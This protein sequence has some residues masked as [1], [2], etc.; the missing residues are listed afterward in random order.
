MTMRR[1]GWLIALVAIC[2]LAACKSDD[3]GDGGG[4]AAGVAGATGGMGGTGTDTGGAGGMGGGA[5]GM[6]GGGAGGMG[7]AGGAGGGVPSA[8][9]SNVGEDVI[10]CPDAVGPFMGTCAPKGTC[11]HRSSNQAKIDALGADAPMELEYRVTQSA[12][13]NHPK[14]LTLP[15]LLMGAS[16]RARTCAGEQ[17]LLWRFVQP[18]MGGMPVAGPGKSNVSIGRYNCNGTFSYYGPSAAP[19]RAAEGFTDPARWNVVE[20]MTDVDPAM[21]GVEQTHIT[22]ATAPN[23]RLTTSPFF[24]PGT[25]TID[26]EL[27]SSGFE[28]LEFDTSEA[29]RDCQGAWNGSMWETPGIY[30]TFAPLADN[31]KDIIDSV[32]Q[33]FCQL[34]SFSVLMPADRATDC[35][36]LPRCM[37]GTTGCKYVKLPDSL[38]PKDDAE[39]GIFRCHL[40]AQGNVNAEDGYPD[41]AALNC[42][43]D[44]PAAALDPDVDPTVSLGQ[45]CDPLGAETGG[46]PACNAFR[47][48][49]KFAA[50]ASEITDTNANELPPVCTM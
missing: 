15:I 32:T 24:L 43:P 29:G 42:T 2:S 35:L 23:R 21:M 16:E 4:G 13:S 28:F 44:A 34:L 46:L 47:I 30:Q 48:I 11:C 31:N 38:C 41:D 5:G 20:A 33:N 27:A 37:P 22:W 14:S 8:E 12:A 17:C 49:N 9:C 6:A 19:A 39:R 50:A 36:A 25:Q 1:H 3:G 45:C 7:G 40:G 26:W 18:R 10:S